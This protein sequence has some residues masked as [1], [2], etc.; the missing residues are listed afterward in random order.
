MRE[1]KNEIVFRSWIMVYIDL[2]LWVIKTFFNIPF[3][4][5]IVQIKLQD[6]FILRVNLEIQFDYLFN[7]NKFH[8]RINRCLP[9]Y[10]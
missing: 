10:I 4:I 8:C 9:I 2:G 3:E 7:N 6:Q 1:Q 5:A